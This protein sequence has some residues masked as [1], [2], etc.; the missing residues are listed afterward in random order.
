M[1]QEFERTFGKREYIYILSGGV[2]STN[3]TNWITWQKPATAKFVS[4][5]CI[6]GGGGGSGG[7]ASAAATAASGGGG[8]GG[9]AVSSVILP[10]FLIPRT[11]YLQ[12]GCGGYGGTGQVQGGAAATAGKSGFISFVH[13]VEPKGNN[14][15][16]LCSA[17]AGSGATAASGSTPGTGGTA[18]I[19]TPNSLAVLA[20]MGFGFN[21]IGGIVGANGGSTGGAGGTIST[22]LTSGNIWNV[23]GAGG[24]G[25]NA[26]T[27]TSAGGDVTGTAYAPTISGGLAGGGRGGDNIFQNISYA[28]LGDLP[29]IT[30]PGSGGGGNT[31]AGTGGAGGHAGMGCGGG[32]GGGTNGTSS[33]GGAGGNGGPGCIIIACW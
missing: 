9:G 25:V 24:G 33:V 5:I 13:S 11:F 16:V 6:G 4:I 8:G 1:Y 18:A 17:N 29:Q 23:G 31:S 12:P 21:T 15:N 28:D 20:C 19:I 30:G 14:T 27:T 7:G 3:P 26:G 32:G 10:A 2:A 22:W